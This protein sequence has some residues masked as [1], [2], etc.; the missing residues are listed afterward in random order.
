MC[1]PLC[2]LSEVRCDRKQVGMA[3]LSLIL[4][5][6]R[7]GR[8]SWH[9]IPTV[10]LPLPSSASAYSGLSLGICQSAALSWVLL[11]CDRE[12]CGR[13]EKGAPSVCDDS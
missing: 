10:R 1:L 13:R 11:G 12:S 8:P 2:L 3:T 7:L 9:P 6:R 5:P 4:Q